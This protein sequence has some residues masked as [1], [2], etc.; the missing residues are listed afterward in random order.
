MI[1]VIKVKSETWYDYYQC[2]GCGRVWK[3]YYKKIGH[4]TCK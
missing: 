2:R 3:S 4:K 1:P